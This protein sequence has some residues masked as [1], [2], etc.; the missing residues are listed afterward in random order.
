MQLSTVVSVSIAGKTSERRSAV[1]RASAKL[2]HGN[3]LPT[4]QVYFGEIKI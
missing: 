3:D 4:Q 1:L 2:E